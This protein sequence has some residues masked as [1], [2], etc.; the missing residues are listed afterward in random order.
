MK[1][2]KKTLSFLPLSL[3]ILLVLV[4]CSATSQREPVAELLDTLGSAAESVASDEP[5]A[6][7][8]PPVSSPGLMAAA[9]GTLTQI[10]EEV[11]PSVVHIQ[12]VKNEA[13]LPSFIHPEVPGAPD[14][15]TPGEPPQAFG[16]GSGF[17]WDKEGH[18]VTNNHVVE[19]AEKITV[20]FADETSV[21]AELVGA[22]PDSDLAVL[23][24]DLPAGL[25]KPVQLGDSANLQVGELAIAI[26]NPFGQEGTMTVGIISALGRLLPVDSGLSLAPRYNIP[27]IIQTDAAINPATRAACCLMTRASSLA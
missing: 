11:N 3:V 5:A 10:Y 26:G 19:G 9:E 25:L 2:T 4:G 17:V 12:V 24:V 16:E 23:K 15:S 13:G 27:D 22:D 21:K 7:D 18:I 14:G 1:G 8:L 20:V 6:L